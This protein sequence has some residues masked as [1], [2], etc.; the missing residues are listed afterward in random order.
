MPLKEGGRLECQFHG[1]GMCRYETKKEAIAAWNTRA[2]SQPPD[3]VIEALGELD[4]CISD[5]LSLA[6]K[7]GVTELTRFKF[8]SQMDLIR[9]HIQGRD[10]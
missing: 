5:I 1:F 10:K 9:K 8:N 2:L 4:E 7:C 6:H 3:E